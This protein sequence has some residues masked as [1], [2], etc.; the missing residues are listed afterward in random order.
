MKKVYSKKFNSAKEIIQTHFLEKPQFKKLSTHAC[1]IKLISVLPKHLRQHIA[2]VYQKKR[3]LF[4]ALKHP[5]IKMEIDYN[6]NLIKSLLNKI[7]NIDKSCADIEINEIKSFV[8]YKEKKREELFEY[9]CDNHFDERARGEF[10][11][12]SK[13]SNLQKKFEEIRKIIKN[14][15]K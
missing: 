6:H 2:F 3:T 4:I 5:G 15:S 14:G 13:D 9:A 7:K 1:F 8:T 10:K 11:V 12:L